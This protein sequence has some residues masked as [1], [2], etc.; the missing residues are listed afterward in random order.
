MK[1]G[2][3]IALLAT[4]MLS[5]CSKSKKKNSP[6]A[7][8]PSTEQPAQPQ[9]NNGGNTQPG[10]EEETKITMPSDWR[11]VGLNLSFNTLKSGE[12]FLDSRV[13]AVKLSQYDNSGYNATDS[14]Y[15]RAEL[16]TKDL[17][18]G[19]YTE[20][21]KYVEKD[22]VLSIR[23]KCTSDCKLSNDQDVIISV[24]DT[25]NNDEIL[26]LTVSSFIDKRKMSYRGREVT[27]DI[28]VVSTAANYKMKNLDG[29][30]KDYSSVDTSVLR[31]AYVKDTGLSALQ[32]DVKTRTQYSNIFMA[33]D[34]GNNSLELADEVYEDYE[35]YF[36]ADKALDTYITKAQ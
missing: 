2:L 6:A 3:L 17:K 35:I 20:L 7:A 23:A 33:Y 5:A 29:F 30:Q 36:N 18:A 11:V 12:T 1:K 10:V 25:K 26:N 16:S 27:R 9:G 21:A 19:E 8:A 4:A 24:V 14:Q 13:D 28:R 15:I 32:K 31:L 22:S 34:Y